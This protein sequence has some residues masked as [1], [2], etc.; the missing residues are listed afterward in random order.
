MVASD[1]DVSADKSVSR[2]QRP[3]EYRKSSV[4]WHFDG[5]GYDVPE[6]ATIM[7]PRLLAGRL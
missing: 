3:A 1:R 6:F 2:N 7:S 5:F 4:I